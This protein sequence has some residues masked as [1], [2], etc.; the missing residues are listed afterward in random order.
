MV[1]PIYTSGN[2][3]VIYKLLNFVI[4]LKVVN[5]ESGGYIDSSAPFLLER[6]LVLAPDFCWNYIHLLFVCL[7][8]KVKLRRECNRE[9]SYR[10]KRIINETGKKILKANI[11]IMSRVGSLPLFS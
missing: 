6:G 1:P 11:M 5:T 4:G 2:T 9:I 7:F 3:N 8:C 10:D